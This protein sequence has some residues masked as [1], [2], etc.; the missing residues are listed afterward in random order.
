MKLS[1]IEKMIE[2]LEGEDYMK[3]LHKHRCKS[4][5][6]IWEH[7][8]ECS[9]ED[10]EKNHACPKCGKR[11]SFKHYGPEEINYKFC[12]EAKYECVKEVISGVVD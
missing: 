5:G 11:E 6:C 7:P 2:S 8:N 10:F 3:G 4:C 9:Y 12:G 1:E